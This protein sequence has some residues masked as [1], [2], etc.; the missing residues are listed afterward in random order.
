MFLHHSSKSSS[1][2]FLFIG[3]SLIEKTESPI[4]SSDNSSN[5]SLAEPYH[6]VHFVMEDKNGKLNCPYL[7]KKNIE[8]IGVPWCK[9]L[10]KG[11]ID[12]NWTQEERNTLVSYY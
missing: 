2:A 12:N 10:N 3:Q 4:P 9:Y 11:G 8:G 6:L 7:I 5:M 1:F